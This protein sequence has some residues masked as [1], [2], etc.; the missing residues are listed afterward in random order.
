MKEYNPT[1]MEIKRLRIQ[2]VRHAK[3][4]IKSLQ[5]AM[6]KYMRGSNVEAQYMEEKINSLIN[7][8]KK[9]QRK[10]D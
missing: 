1:K 7:A 8:I 9:M 4:Y 6:G 3:A 2:D 10:M 5:N